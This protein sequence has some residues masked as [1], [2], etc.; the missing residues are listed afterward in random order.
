MAVFGNPTGPIYCLGLVAPTVPGTAVPLNQN[1]SEFTGFGTPATG[2]KP[3]T[4]AG[5]PAIVVAN[6][7]IF[8][9]PKANTGQVYICYKGGN[10]GVA[11]SIIAEV[12]GNG[13][14]ILAAPQS[15]NP[16]QLDQ[17]VIDADN[18]SQGVHVTAIIL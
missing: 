14:F 1:V 9:A 7:I 15:S 13:Y 17:I 4:T 11:N 12:S 16:F 3:Y 10:K 2:V 8:M 5:N 6:Q 18:A